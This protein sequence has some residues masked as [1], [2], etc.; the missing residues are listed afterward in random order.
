MEVNT[1]SVTHI[2]DPGQAKERMDK[3]AELLLEQA[4]N[5]RSRGVLLKLFQSFQSVESERERY[6]TQ[7]GE[8]GQA[9]IRWADGYL[10]ATYRAIHDYLEARFKLSGVSQ[11]ECQ[12]ICGRDQLHKLFHSSSP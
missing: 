6:R 4:H 8:Y 9:T 1:A 10:E 7:I 12:Q 11:H 2:P 3:I 5:P